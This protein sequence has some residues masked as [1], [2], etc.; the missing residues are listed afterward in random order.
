[1]KY[2]TAHTAFGVTFDT[3]SGNIDEFDIRV[4]G[5]VNS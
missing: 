3:S 1:M 4:Y 2:N 5:M